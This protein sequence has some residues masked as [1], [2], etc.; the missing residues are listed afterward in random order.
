MQDNLVQ[1]N[2]SQASFVGT[3]ET[4]KDTA[5]IC[6]EVRL[7]IEEKTKFRK[8]MEQQQQFDS[9]E[10][11]SQSQ[12]DKLPEEVGLTNTDQMDGISTL[13]ISEQE[14]SGERIGSYD[15]KERKDVSLAIIT[16]PVSQLRNKLLV[17]DLNGLL[18]DIV[19][20]PPKTFKADAY[21]GGRAIFK[22]PFCDD[23]L[24]FCFQRFEVGIWSSRLRK[25]VARFLNYLMEDMKHKLLFCWDS[26]HCTATQFN[27]PGYKYKPLVFK[28]MRKIW[29]KHDPDLPWEK[30][31]YNESNTLLIDD[32]PYKAL[33]NPPHTAIFPYSFKFDSND[34]SLGAEGD[35]RAYLERLALSD[36][37]QNFIE[38]NPFGQIAITERSN[39]WSFY[40]QVI[41]ICARPELQSNVSLPA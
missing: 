10:S 41:N 1:V 36:N 23:F 28:E 3:L 4:G 40:S 29:E 34:N 18:A 11:S 5:E 24:R 33:L 7:A 26:S 37:V 2:E 31:Y 8:R 14:N 25:N 16:P 13:T 35:L 30:G 39:D 32:S 6:S 15:T 21:I 12:T 19:Y 27:T 22:R 17:L 38:Q 20:Q 9:S